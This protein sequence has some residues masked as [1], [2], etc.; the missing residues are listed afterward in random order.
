MEETISWKENMINIIFAP[1]Y[2]S[3]THVT[4]MVT[5]WMAEYFAPLFQLHRS[6]VK[7]YDECKW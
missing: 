3:P 5:A 2:L 7:L 1:F 6:N 4:I